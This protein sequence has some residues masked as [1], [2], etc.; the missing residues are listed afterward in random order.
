MP[1]QNLKGFATLALAKAG[2]NVIN[3]EQADALASA[4]SDTRLSNMEGERPLQIESWLRATARRHWIRSVPAKP[5][6]EV[7]AKARPE[8]W[9][10]SAF[11]SGNLVRM[12]LGD[13]QRREAMQIIDCLLA[14]PKERL[15][16]MSYPQA[17][18]LSHKW[19]AEQAKK[20]VTEEDPA[21][22]EVVLDLDGGMR[23]VEVKSPKSL[24]REGSMMRHCVGSY[25]QK[26][27]DGQCKIY[28]LR[29]EMNRPKLTVEACPSDENGELVDDDEQ[30]THLCLDQV[31]GVANALPKVEHANSLR[32][33]TKK[34]EELGTPVADAKDLAQSGMVFDKQSKSLKL[35]EEL[36]KGYVISGPVEFIH[37]IP[38][39]IER[40][41][42]T[43]SLTIEEARLPALLR[44]NSR[45]ITLKNCKAIDSVVEC[46]DDQG[47][48][49]KGTVKV[50]GVEGFAALSIKAEIIHMDGS[51]GQTG[52]MDPSGRASS[53]GGA[54]H[55]MGL[56][57]SMEKLVVDS[58]YFNAYAVGVK[59][60]IM[61]GGPETLGD[62]HALLERCAIGSIQGDLAKMTMIE[63]RLAGA[64]AAWNKQ[65][66]ERPRAARTALSV[67]ENPSSNSEIMEA[68]IRVGSGG[69]PWSD[70]R[71]SKKPEER[72]SYQL[73]KMLGSFVL[74]PF[75]S[76]SDGVHMSFGQGNV[77]GY[78]LPYFEN[79]F[80]KQSLAVVD[81]LRAQVKEPDQDWIKALGGQ[82]DPGLASEK[83]DGEDFAGKKFL[84]SQWRDEFK[85]QCPGLASKMKRRSDWEKDFACDSK[86]I[87]LIEAI[88]D[89]RFMSEEGELR[90]MWMAG[91]K[92]KKIKSASIEET[93]AKLDFHDDES[94]AADLSKYGPWRMARFLPYLIGPETVDFEIDTTWVGKKTVL[95]HALGDLNDGDDL[96]YS[97]DS[98]LKPLDPKS[99]RA[100]ILAQCLI[101]WPGPDV[102]LVARPALPQSL[103][104]LGES[105]FPKNFAIVCAAGASMLSK[106]S[107]LGE[108]AAPML[109]GE[110]FDATCKALMLTDGSNV[111]KQKDWCLRMA[112]LDL[113]VQAGG[114][115]AGSERG[116]IGALAKARGIDCQ[117]YMDNFDATNFLKKNQDMEPLGLVDFKSL[118]DAFAVLCPK[119]S[120][121]EKSAGLAQE[122]LA[123]RGLS[124]SVNSVPVLDGLSQKLAFKRLENMPHFMS[125]A[126]K[127]TE[128]ESF[129]PLMQKGFDGPDGF[130]IM[131]EGLPLLEVDW[132]HQ[133]LKG[134]AANEVFEALGKA[135][136]ERAL[137]LPAASIL[138]AMFEGVEGEALK[139]MKANIP[140]EMGGAKKKEVESLLALGMKSFPTC[141]GYLAKVDDGVSAEVVTELLSLAKGGKAL[142]ELSK[143]SLDEFTL[144]Y[145]TETKKSI[146]R[147]I[148]NQQHFTQDMR[149]TMIDMLSHARHYHRPA[150]G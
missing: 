9:A 45:Y 107:G 70:S 123:A 137:K 81:E 33:L 59:E 5:V 77:W 11:E 127:R 25:A 143:K 29:D 115:L 109:A 75:G 31:R 118:S 91:V 1:E 104:D 64:P 60:F 53:L 48:I 27:A 2:R 44:I 80:G 95:A 40:L 120:L 99:N 145:T 14:L 56:G 141:A 47:F 121:A 26:V 96:D 117:K 79:M 21:G 135:R 87:K 8:S 82:W 128:I 92:D 71:Q 35:Y 4:L 85:R 22:I 122:R 49:E 114:A 41:V 150:M 116:L 100:A 18:S 13:E 78:S 106:A 101:L 43:G 90:K 131:E 133:G 113:N 50:E 103:I 37:R 63:G 138:C 148:S 69:R 108:P 39:G 24:E 54:L 124:Q 97:N 129:Y 57:K 73:G 32:A 42:F 23:W 19:H 17:L 112:A 132:I 3:P 126:Q 130:P 102:E 6:D 83:G 52:W 139:W 30:P 46:V 110:L 55:V 140:E 125:A 65:G 134:G 51:L 88:C 111:A 62:E 144:E 76:L 146:A 84:L 119:D 38:A 147:F 142:A 149:S 105:D 10:M 89:A 68:L 20:K 16:R 34:F 7:E 61:K 93:A 66:G 67:M 74:T 94:A 15:A 28:S 98:Y 72:A 86:A 12:N 58:K 36:L 136:D